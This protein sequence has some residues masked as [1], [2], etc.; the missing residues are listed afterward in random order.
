MLI[1]NHQK[2][3]LGIDQKD[4]NTLGFNDLSSLRAEVPDFADL[5]VKIPG[6]IHNFKHVHWI[7]FITCAESNEKSKAIINVN[8]KS[9]KCTID[10]KTAYLVDN[11][12]SEAYLVY[13]NN[14]RALTAQEHEHI[15]ANIPNRPTI[16]EA[17]NVHVEEKEI[18]APIEETPTPTTTIDEFDVPSITEDEVFQEPFEE[19]P[20]I[21]EDDFKLDVDMD[22]DYDY[23]TV[24]SYAQ[25]IHQPDIP[26]VK[27]EETPPIQAEQQKETYI[28]DP[29]VA[30]EE[31]GLP[32]DL[33]EEFIQDFILQAKE[34]KENLYKSLDE[35]D[36]ENVKILSHKL[37]GVAAN[38]RIEDA[39]EVLSTINTTSDLGVI[40]T[41]L[42]ELYRIIAKLAG[43]KQEESPEKQKES[44]IVQENAPILEEETTLQEPQ[45]QE[46]KIDIQLDDDYLDIDFKDNEEE[47]DS[48]EDF[49]NNEDIES[50]DEPE[51]ELKMEMEMETPKEEPSSSEEEIFSIEYSKEN[52]ANE[53]GLDT[54]SFNELLNDYAQESQEIL[55]HISS[56]VENDDFYS[57]ETEALKLRGMTENMRI[58]E[59][60]EEMGVLLHE[61]EDKEKILRSI[62]KISKLIQHINAAR[63]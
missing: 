37:K 18:Q 7:D 52:V 57:Y 12:A 27:Q 17:A 39:F 35:G 6:H 11:P 40:K 24:E 20:A 2:E 41:S 23:E 14:L 1:Y 33:I 36:L 43:E 30:S 34:F 8:S 21:A 63:D 31:L 4:L 16:P 60:N 51:P 10:V 59:F 28:Y 47:L 61:K 55:S 5:F 46:E 56:Y 22:D 54:E 44:L 25:T 62:D 15:V 50:F 9:F 19:A 29:H 45:A 26:Q 58:N 49:N 38:L 32:L 42:D 3:F 53:I 13:L 48:Q